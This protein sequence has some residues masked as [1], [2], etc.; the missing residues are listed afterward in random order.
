MSRWFHSLKARAVQPRP[1]TH[2]MLNIR[3]YTDFPTCNLRCSYC[4]AG[5]GDKYAKPQSQWNEQRFLT[6][7]DNIGKLP[8]DVNVRFGVGGEFFVS[9][10]LVDAARLLSHRPNIVSLNLITNLTLSLKQYE[11]LFSGYR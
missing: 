11:K 5:H 8:F 3:Y 6:I 1:T 7:V 2:R 9:R 4:I 10:T